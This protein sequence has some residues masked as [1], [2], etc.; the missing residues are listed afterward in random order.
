ME[1]HGLIPLPVFLSVSEGRL[2]VRAEITVTGDSFFSGEMKLAMMLLNGILPS[3]GT[4]AGV[5]ISCIRSPSPLREEEYSL[6]TSASGVRIVSDSRS[7]MYRG[8]Q[9]FRQLMLSARPENDFTV[10]FLEIRDAPRFSWRGFMLDTSRH[11]Y[12]VDFIKKM[13]DVASLHMMNTFHWHLTDDQGW[14]LPVAGY[15]LLTEIGSFRHDR[16]IILETLEGGWYSESQI[17]DIVRYAGQR[18]VQVVPE[19]DL[20]GHASAILAA[21]PHLGCTGGPYRVEDRFGVFEDILCVGNPDII[22]FFESIFDTL[23]RLFLSPYVHIGGDEVPKTCW[24]ACPS[25]QAKRESLGLDETSH[26]QNWVT[27]LLAEMLRKRGKTAIGWDEVLEGS[28][29]FPL[30]ENLVVMSWRGREGGIAASEKGHRVIMSPLTDGCY[31]NFRHQDSREEPGHLGVTTVTQS[32]SFEP[33]PRDM[34]DTQEQLVLGGQ[35]NMW[36]EV[37]YAS[38]IAEYMFFPRLCAIAEALWSP[39]ESRSINS[40][41]R[42][43]A[44]HRMRLDALDV[45]YY[46]GSFS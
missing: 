39:K 44:I 33:V 36:S 7:G 1:D 24:D 32:Y 34:T 26:L 5:H 27:S 23:T 15:P 37:I 43:M 21:Y 42:R 30:P 11:F 12:S 4:D 28:D 8:L 3:G 13:I 31:L 10:P 14:R 2:P 18:H 20:P 46:T 45:R 38:R 25:C 6:I 22:P 41:S 40:F 9:R 29:Q 17:E 16:R 19:V 35:C